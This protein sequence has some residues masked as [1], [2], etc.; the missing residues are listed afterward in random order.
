MT[1]EIGG[2]GPYGYEP[3][4]ER[5]AAKAG[6]PREYVVYHAGNIDGELYRSD[7]ACPSAATQCWLSG[8]RMIPLLTILD[9]IGANVRDSTAARKKAFGLASGRVGTQTYSTNPSRDSVQPA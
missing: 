6:V 7:R 5:L 2:T 1:L 8:P 3:L 4:M 9:Y